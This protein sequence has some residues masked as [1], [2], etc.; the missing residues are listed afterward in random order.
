MG[1]TDHSDPNIFDEMMSD[2][3]S[4]KW[5]DA[6]KSKI[7]SIY[8]NQVWILVDPSERIIFIRCK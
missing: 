4:E 7:D 2:I 5:L 1:D 8:S 3:D 6:M